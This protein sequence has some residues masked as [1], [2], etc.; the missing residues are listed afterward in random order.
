MPATI[1]DNSGVPTA[2]QQARSGP[3]LTRFPAMMWGIFFLCIG[4]PDYVRAWC[5]PCR[6]AVFP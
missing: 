4:F 2:E 3:A 6:S 1:T 5:P